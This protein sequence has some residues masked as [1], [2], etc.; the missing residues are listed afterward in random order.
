M[1]NTVC[2][3]QH[4]LLLLLLLLTQQ[5]VA[6]PGLDTLSPAE[7]HSWTWPFTGGC[8]S[9]PGPAGWWG[10]GVSRGCPSSL[11]LYPLN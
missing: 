1:L 6:P 11:V 7:G 5:L 2:G 4:S 10:S 9:L 8:L 3:M